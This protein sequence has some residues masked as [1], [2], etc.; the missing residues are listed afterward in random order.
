[1]RRAGAGWA[2]TAAA[3]AA[4]ALAIFAAPV[5]PATSAGQPGAA[6]R[7]LLDMLLADMGKMVGPRLRER[8]LWRAYLSA[9]TADLQQQLDSRDA[10]DRWDAIRLDWL[11]QCFDHTHVIAPAKVLR[12][13]RAGKR[14]VLHVRV[15]MITG[16]RQDLTVV[17][18]NE[19]NT[20]ESRWRIDDIID[21]QGARFT[22]ALTKGLRDHDLR[23]GP[24]P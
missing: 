13:T 14:A 5:L 19:G 3:L 4:A 6:P 18:V 1:M 9:P 22:A 11:C 24:L 8:P 23:R 16:E 2:R 15:A 17:F 7:R 12:Q 21:Q 10:A 20:R